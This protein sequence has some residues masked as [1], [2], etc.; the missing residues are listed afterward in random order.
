MA[1]NLVVIVERVCVCFIVAAGILPLKFMIDCFRLVVD[2][3]WSVVINTRGTV[4]RDTI[5]SSVERDPNRLV[6]DDHMKCVLC[7]C[8]IEKVRFVLPKPV[9]LAGSMG[10]QELLSEARNWRFSERTKKE[11]F[12]TYSS[13]HF[14]VVVAA[15]S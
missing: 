15:D 8:W 11:L 2:G 12:S 14:S 13:S 5:V 9:C 3:D 1:L 7:L 6:H 4:S 10:T